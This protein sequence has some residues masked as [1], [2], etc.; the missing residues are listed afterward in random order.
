MVSRGASRAFGGRGGVGGVPR[1][2]ASFCVPSATPRRAFVV[3]PAA[4]R[5]FRYDDRASVAFLGRRERGGSPEAPV[6]E[7]RV[8]SARS[9]FRPRRGGSAS[10]DESAPRAPASHPHRGARAPLASASAP[11]ASRARRRRLSG[12]RR[13]RRAAASSGAGVSVARLI[14]AMSAADDAVSLV[15][16]P[17]EVSARIMRLLDARD[18]AALRSTCVRAFDA[19]LVEA[20]ALEAV[21]ARAPWRPRPRVRRVVRPGRDARRDAPIRR[22]RRRRRPP[23]AARVRVHDG[24]HRPTRRVP[25]LGPR[26][27]PPRRGGSRGG[28]RGGG[29]GVDPGRA[30]LRRP[31][32]D[33]QATHQAD[34]RIVGRPSSGV[35][36]RRRRP[37]RHPRRVACAATS[38]AFNV[39][40]GVGGSDPLTI[41]RNAR[42]LSPRSRRRFRDVGPP[43][44]QL[45]LL[46][47]FGSSLDR[48]LASLR[49]APDRRAFGPSARVVS[50]AVG[51][52][53]VLC[54]TSR[55]DAHAWG[56]RRRGPAR[57]TAPS[58]IAWAWRASRSEGRA[59]TRGG[60]ANGVPKQEAV[61]TRRRGRGGRVRE[62]AAVERRV[63]R[64]VLQGY[65]DA[66][67]GV[68]HL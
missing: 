18:L 16:L 55:G 51:R 52:M 11:L 15:D 61:K 57:A 47:V 48:L 40:A 54:A 56:A 9:R 43:P 41:L 7:P 12:R 67:R 60:V 37:R 17:R 45:L 62:P 2:R 66:P 33:P 68:E 65:D 28:S 19:S 35:P 46:P 39:V 64:R 8:A 50:I 27:G 24:R 49:V 53:H 58:P 10:A 22:A 63:R 6:A 38:E 14:D 42:A 21:R 29:S 59:A 13:G 23:R 44:P 36:L 26:R 25:Q 34:P 3:V 4:T 31:S 20:A 30:T 32:G 5:P 1:K